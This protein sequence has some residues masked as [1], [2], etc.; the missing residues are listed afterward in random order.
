MD[1]PCGLSYFQT[2]LILQRVCQ[3]QIAKTESINDCSACNVYIISVFNY[4]LSPVC[5]IDWQR[6]VEIV[7]S[8]IMYI[9][10]MV[11]PESSLVKTNRL[12]R[13]LLRW[14]TGADTRKDW[15]VVL[16]ALWHHAV[17]TR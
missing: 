4:N 2:T 12:F 7:F 8:E 15:I 17:C 6:Q 13:K 14:S 1:S 10:K 11:K 3:K 5:D 9:L 16:R